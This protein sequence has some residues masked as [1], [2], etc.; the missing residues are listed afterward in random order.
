MFQR[1]QTDLQ[2][3]EKNQRYL[4]LFSTENREAVVQ[5]ASFIAY[6]CNGS[7]VPPHPVVCSS[8]GLLFIAAVGIAK[9]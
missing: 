4:Q 8:L 6:Y 1:L 5:T 3:G 7:N 9:K 2:D